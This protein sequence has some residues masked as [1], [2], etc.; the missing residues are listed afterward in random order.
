M[1]Y[2]VDSGP[3]TSIAPGAPFTL[4]AGPHAISY[5]STDLLGGVEPTRTAALF[6]DALPPETTATVSN[7]TGGKLVTL[8]ASDRA[9]GV[10]WTEYRIDS[11][12][13]TRY[14]GPALISA[15]GNHTVEFRSADRLGNLE[16][17]QSVTVLVE[18]TT[19]GASAGFNVKPALALVLAATL[20]LAGWFAAPSPDPPR[21]RRWFLTVVLP[22]A[23]V[24][25]S[26]G[27][28][29]LAVPEMAVPGGSLGL[30]VD[31]ALLLIGLLVIY[32]S[33]KRILQSA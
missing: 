32:L 29:S 23:V 27:A 11:G 5:N 13:W 21:R 4:P 12:A 9:S 3:W 14:G 19:T 24:E 6:V 7:G 10:D 15:P 33:R 22:P 26:T 30:P 2:R 17:A 28:V 25:A 31:A 20:V 18:A 8:A 16:P 1:W